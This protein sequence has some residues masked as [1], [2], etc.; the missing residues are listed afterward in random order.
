[1]TAAEPRLADA[2][3]Y[4]RL[5]AQ[6]T[7]EAVCDVV[8]TSGGEISAIYLSMLERGERNPSPE[9]LDR[10]LTALGSERDELARLYRQQPWSRN[11]SLGASSVPRIRGRP[12]SAAAPIA[13]SW[14]DNVAVA[15]PVSED[16][17]LRELAELWPAIAASR[18][19]ELIRLARRYAK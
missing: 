13:A 7:Q 14:S 16:G 6:L 15:A 10:L 4:L 9:M 8:R 3:R 12:R 18:Q 1:M 2:L 5:R 11:R 17:S 19:R